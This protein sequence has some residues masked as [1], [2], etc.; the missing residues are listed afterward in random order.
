[1]SYISFLSSSFLPLSLKSGE[2]FHS[3]KFL[4]NMPK[5]YGGLR[6]GQYWWRAREQCVVFFLK[7]NFSKFPIG[8]NC[9]ET[10]QGKNRVERVTLEMRVAERRN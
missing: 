1:M 4:P 9:Q 6:L 5:L 3:N 2:H 8:Q 7:G 10:L